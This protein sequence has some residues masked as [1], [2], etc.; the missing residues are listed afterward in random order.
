[1]WLNDLLA[2]K[3]FA[4]GPLGHGKDSSHFYFIGAAGADECGADYSLPAFL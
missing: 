3:D 4:S 1:L 2:K